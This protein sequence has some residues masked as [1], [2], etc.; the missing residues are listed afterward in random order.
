MVTP[1]VIE[2][3][4]SH[5]LL[6]VSTDPLASILTMGE[7]IELT[8]TATTRVTENG[9][10]EVI[11]LCLYCSLLSSNHVPLFSVPNKKDA[12][13]VRFHPQERVA[14]SLFPFSYTFI[15]LVRRLD[16]L[17]SILAVS[18][19]FGA[20]VGESHSLSSLTSIH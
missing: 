17:S 8:C 11:V 13:Q 19:A 2:L 5:P 6:R 10:A 4:Y 14:L 3:G 20:S 16:M 1:V 7:D 18:L 12:Y 15:T 9:L